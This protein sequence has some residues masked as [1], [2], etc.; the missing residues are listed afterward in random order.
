M[1]FIKNGNISLIKSPLILEYISVYL[2][3]TLPNKSKLKAHLSKYEI[4]CSNFKFAKQREE[5]YFKILLS[6]L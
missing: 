3:L 2:T 5:N 4:K 1:E 6:L